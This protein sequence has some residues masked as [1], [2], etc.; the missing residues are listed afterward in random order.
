MT[1][2]IVV[3]K[4]LFLAL[5]D[6][7]ADSSAAPAFTRFPPTTTDLDFFGVK[8]QKQSLFVCSFT[9]SLSLSL[10]PHRLRTPF[11]TRQNRGL[12]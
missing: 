9:L 5:A 10:P 8:K 2:F 11:Q 7:K 4:T 3:H 6:Y 1:G 12:G